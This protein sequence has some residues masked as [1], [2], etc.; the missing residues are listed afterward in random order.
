MAHLSLRTLALVALAT[1]GLPGGSGENALLLVDP[2]SA[3]ALRAANHYKH[4]RQIPDCNVLYMEPGAPTYADFVTRNQASLL[5]ELDARGI[6][7]HIDYIVVMPGSGFY[8]PASGYVS[9]SCFPVNRFGLAGAYTTTFIAADV[10]AGVSSGLTNRYRTAGNDPL[11]FDSEV[12]Y[13][14]GSP[15]TAAGARRYFISSLLG[16]TGERGNTIEEILALVDRSV[17]ADGT[18]PL[19]TTYFMHTTDT[20]RSAPRHGAYPNI[21]SAI[22]ALGGAAQVLFADLPLGQHDALGIMTG[23]ANPDIDGADLTLLPGSFAD[24]LTSYAGTFDTASQTKMS[25]WIAKGASGTSGT[26][27]EPCNY[28]GKFPHARLHLFLRAGL[29]LGEA[30]LRSMTYVPFQNLLYGDPLARPFAAAPTVDLPDAPVGLVSGSV[31]LHPV[32]VATAPGAVVDTLE[33]LVDGVLARRLEPGQAFALAT[34]T[35]A[36]GWHELRVL[37]YDDTPVRS[38]GRWIGSFEVGN[39]GRSAALTPSVVVGDQA[40]AFDFGLQAQG[41]GLVEQRLVQNGRVLAASAANPASL[42]LY[43][44]NLGAGTSRVQAEALYTDGELVRSAPLQL[45]VAATGAGTSGLAPVAFDFHHDLRVDGL[46]VLEL[47]AAF[48]DALDSAT[49]AVTV[50]SGQTVVLG[51]FKAFRW[52]DPNPGAS[53]T[54]TLVYDVTTPSGTSN[55]GTIT[56]RYVQPPVCPSP[57]NYCTGAQNSQGTSAA[58]GSSGSTSLIENELVL[59]VTGAVPL[60]FGLFFYGSAQVQT[61][62]GDGFLCVGPGGQGLFRL[63]PP[64]ASDFLGSN[65]RVLDL[66]ESPHVFGAGAIEAGSTWNFQ[67]WYRDSVTPA[68]F[69][70]SD[71]LAVEFCP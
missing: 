55:S 29:S 32:A 20:T 3:E 13:L 27:E 16:Y 34:S 31:L 28:S 53:G 7:D 40:Q 12:A 59:Y 62:L 37:A 14:G 17:A 25:R 8:V 50:P 60:K 66:N 33:V 15:S 51:G 42:K 26:V 45:D 48:D 2:S 52:L 69:N 43:G 44:V 11:A 1:P 18:F 70:L 68:G 64:V 36:D 23:L 39:H 24:H 41:A 65:Q 9:D 54:D 6:A 46:H 58:M 22:I 63:P 61:P 30:W 21:A 19:G 71:G 4:A 56:L 57:S 47:P 5:S 35:L 67:Y 38:V 49:F 10:L